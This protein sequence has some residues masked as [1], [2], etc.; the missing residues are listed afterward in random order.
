MRGEKLGSL[1]KSEYYSH[2]YDLLQ[3]NNG[4][5]V[6]A[7]LMESPLSEIPE[8]LSATASAAYAVFDAE[9]GHRF[10]P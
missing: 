3:N 6:R 8:G 4:A 7:T 10:K 9:A 5:E 2:M 1:Y